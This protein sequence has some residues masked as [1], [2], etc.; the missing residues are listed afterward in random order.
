MAKPWTCPPR[1]VCINFEIL[2]ICRTICLPRHQKGRHLTTVPLADAFASKFTS[3][4]GVVHRVADEAGAAEALARI[5]GEISAE[6]VA[7]AGLDPSFQAMLV[8]ASKAAGAS[9]MTPPYD[10]AD[11]P[12]AVDACQIGV[13]E[14]AFTIAE[15][16]TLVEVS[17][18]DAIRL[19]SSLPR[20][21]VGIVRASTL[22]PSL[23]EAAPLMR[24][25]FEDNDGGVVLS[26]IS[27]PSRTGDIEL[28]L[29]LGVHGPEVAHAILIEDAS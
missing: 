6:R 14:A 20:T 13:T 8:E 15:T 23:R 3:L 11:L 16:G 1:P 27:G 4:S 19:V 29:T 2:T 5:I 7:F 24:P 22:V 25:Y 18:N 28:K 17:T 21:H 12:H 26:F 9:V 10:P